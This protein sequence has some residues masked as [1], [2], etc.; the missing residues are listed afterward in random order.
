VL[1][2]AEEFGMDNPLWMDSTGAVA[3][4]YGIHSVPRAYLVERSGRVWV[5]RNLTTERVSMMFA[6]ARRMALVR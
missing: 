6:I 1:A 5:Y 3:T 4:A 2:F